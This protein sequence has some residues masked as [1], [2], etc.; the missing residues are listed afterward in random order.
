MNIYLT[1]AISLQRKLR[2][3]KLK[4]QVNAKSKETRKESGSRNKGVTKSVD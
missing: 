1:D 2:K 3:K 4:N